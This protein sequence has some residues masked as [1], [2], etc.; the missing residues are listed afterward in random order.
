MNFR[1]MS[2]SRKC[3]FFCWD[4]H[5]TLQTFLSCHKLVH[6]LLKC[7]T[8]TRRTQVCQ[9]SCLRFWWKISWRFL[10][11]WLSRLERNWMEKGGPGLSR[12][13]SLTQIWSVLD[14][15]MKK[16]LQPTMGTHIL[17]MAQCVGGAR[18]CSPYS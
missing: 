9:G 8:G 12:F 14:R 6:L 7:Y 10:G 2:F 3:C 4:T 1:S 17:F 15:Q 11:A 16:T 13:L 18:L 5:W